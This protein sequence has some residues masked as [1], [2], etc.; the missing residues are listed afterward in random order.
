MSYYNEWGYDAAFGDD[1]EVIELA[2]TAVNYRLTVDVIKS[3]ELASGTY[4][5]FSPLSGQLELFHEALYIHPDVDSAEWNEQDR[6]Q[7]MRYLHKLESSIVGNNPTLRKQL[8]LL[9]DEFNETFRG[10]Y[11]D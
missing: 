2:M 9:I 11:H 3:A 6:K 4:V 10:F 5:S 1:S 7:I 8:Y